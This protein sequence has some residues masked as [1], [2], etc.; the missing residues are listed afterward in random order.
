MGFKYTK[1]TKKNL[2]KNK[3]KWAVIFLIPWLVQFAVF[4]VYPL[5]YGFFISFTDFSLMH[6][7]EISFVGFENYKAIPHDPAFISSV[8]AT[9]GYAAFIIPLTIVL[10]LWASFLLQGYG[11]KMNTFSKALIYLPGVACTTALVIVW[12]FVFMPG[13]GILSSFLKGVGL[14][15]FSV[16]DNPATSIPI[17][18][19]LILSISLGQPVILYSAAMNSIPVTYYEAAEI[20]GASR[21]KQFFAITLPLLQPTNIFVTVTTTIAVLQVF[22]VP[23]LMTGGGPQYKTSSLL[24]M[25]Y[26]SAFQNGSFGYASAVGIVLFLFTAAVAALQF[27]LMRREVHEY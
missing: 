5:V 13:G 25:V 10:A 6:V 1:N 22:V 3:A 23:Y 17:L 26:K 19:I 2:A 16:F 21:T 12:K 7:E 4:T 20:D 11:D 14:P 15:L 24:M 8:I 18:S 27:R 9:V